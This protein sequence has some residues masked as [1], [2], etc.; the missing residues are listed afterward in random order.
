[1]RYDIIGGDT[2]S[3]KVH[4]Y[5]IFDL[6]ELAENYKKHNFRFLETDYSPKG[7]ISWRGSYDT[8]AIDY[9]TDKISGKELAKVLKKGLSIAHT[10]YK[11]GDYRYGDDEEFYVASYGRSEEHKVVGYENKD[12]EIILLTR[13]DPY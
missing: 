1:M 6:I 2:K 5:R 8:P 11:G 9:C 4:F 7:I 3:E 13:I 10:G 12:N